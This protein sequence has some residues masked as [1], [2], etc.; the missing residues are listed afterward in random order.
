MHII[1]IV[2]CTYVSI[3]VVKS[4]V[5]SRLA[6]T[7]QRTLLE[8]GETT[9][10]I[11]VRLVYRRRYARRRETY[12][13][14]GIQLFLSCLRFERRLIGCIFPEPVHPLHPFPFSLLDVTLIRSR[15]LAARLPPPLPLR[16]VLCFFISAILLLSSTPGIIGVEFRLPM[17]L[18]ALSR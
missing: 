4:C 15:V 10:Y 1:C 3:L 17:F 8:C 2:P 16:S 18:S 6:S 13:A 5:S 7:G 9:L 11:V 12:R 14:R